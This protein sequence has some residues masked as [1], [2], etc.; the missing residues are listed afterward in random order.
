[1][2]VNKVSAIVRQLQLLKNLHHHL[3]H[4]ETKITYTTDMS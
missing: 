1:M 2:D 4:Y 3:K